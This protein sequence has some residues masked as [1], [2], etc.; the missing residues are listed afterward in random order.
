MT[1][2]HPRAGG[3]TFA[4]GGSPRSAGRYEFEAKGL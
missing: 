4:Q 2:P 1:T 3:L